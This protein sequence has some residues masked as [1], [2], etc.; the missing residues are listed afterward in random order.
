MDLRQLTDTFYVS[1][2][3]QADD[4]DALRAAGITTIICN[5][6]DAEVPSEIQADAIAMAAAAAGMTF[7]RVP[8]TQQTMTPENVMT[9]RALSDDADGP[10]LAYCAS[11]TR[12]CV[13]W[14][15]GQAK[16]R[17]VAE[18]IAIARKA[19]YELANIRPTLEAIAQHGL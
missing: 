11:G 18:I 14:A 3:I 15:L 8:L 17:P 16:D 12:S 10:V 4:M 5:R 1:P 7:F 19:G 9:Q 13:A 6:P 2:Q